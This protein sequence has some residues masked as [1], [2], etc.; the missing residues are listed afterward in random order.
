MSWATVQYGN[1][2]YAEYNTRNLVRS[3]KAYSL[4][5]IY[6]HIIIYLPYCI[7]AHDMTVLFYTIMLS[8]SAIDILAKTA[9]IVA[10]NWIA[11]KLA[12]ISKAD[13]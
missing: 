3:G 4:S 7:G 6:Y 5:Y 12:K 1:I 2:L 8:R 13:L 10:V 11:D 9:A